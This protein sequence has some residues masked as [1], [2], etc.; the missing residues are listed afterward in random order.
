MAESE[1]ELKSLLMKAKVE[2]EKVGLK[3]NIQKTK[4]M[5][6]GPITSREIDG[7]TVEIVSDFIFWGSKISADGGCSHEIKRR[8][9]LGRK[10]MTNLDSIFKSRD[11]TLPTKVRLFKAMVFPVVMCGC[12]SWTVKKAEH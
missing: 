8:L 10:V 3:L 4:I 9:L 1:E 7:E 11:I 12:E 5:V 2:S 6:S